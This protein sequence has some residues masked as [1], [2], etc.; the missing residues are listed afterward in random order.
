MNF[1]GRL[2]LLRMIV[3]PVFIGASSC[4]DVIDPNLAKADPVVNVDAWIN[5]KPEPQVIQITWTVDYDNNDQLPPPVSGCT[6]SVRDD[7]G[8]NYLFL[9]DTEKKDGTYVW[10]PSDIQDSFGGVGR[11][12]TLTV[13][14]P[15]VVDR[16]SKYNGEVLVAESFMGPV[17]PIDDITYEPDQGHGMN[18]KD[19][20]YQAEFKGKDLP[21]VGNCYWI[22][23]YKNTVYLNQPAE[24]NIAYDAGTSRDSGFDGISFIPPIRSGINPGEGDTTDDRPA[25]Y[26]FNDSIYVEIHSITEA[27]YNY[28][29]QVIASTDRKTGIGSI[30]SSKPLSNASTNIVS[31]GPVIVGFFN[32]ASVKGYGE[33]IR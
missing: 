20:G 12:F 25:P 30:F 4:E 19:E 16:D 8:N 13:Q 24:I 22:R 28:L 18:R 7:L 29:S 27:A 33:I 11:S 17:P 21:G 6:V 9:E 2:F 15:S 14:F 26:Q 10:M 5:D 23:T 32:T 31:S 1:N 3:V